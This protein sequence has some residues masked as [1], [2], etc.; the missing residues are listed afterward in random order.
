M[1]WK[2][3]KTELLL[4]SLRVNDHHLV[5]RLIVIRSVFYKLSDSNVRNE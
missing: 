3:L 4:I 2:S 1:E 5:E